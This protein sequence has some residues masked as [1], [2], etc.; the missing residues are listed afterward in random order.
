MQ[1]NTDIRSK[2]ENLIL[3]NPIEEVIDEHVV[4][5]NIDSN[6]S[7]IW[8]LLFM[9]GYLKSTSSSSFGDGTIACTMQI[10]NNE[11][12]GF[13]KRLVKECFA[14]NNSISWYNN[15]ITDLTS[16]N[17]DSFIK[18]LERI[19]LNIVSTKDTE[20]PEREKFYHGL[21]LGL[22]VGLEDSYEIRSNK[23]SGLGF[24]DLA[25]I[26]KDPK[27]HKI[28]IV[29]ELKKAN[30][31]KLLPAKADEAFAQINTKKYD[32][33]LRAR[34]IKKIVKIGIAFSAKTLQ[35]KHE[36]LEL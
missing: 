33:E 11:I 4:F 2:I 12:K 17:I 25:L 3:G 26:P 13:Y 28:G 6:I 19:M 16:G 24:Y 31:D 9:A 5:A 34:G 20:N 14:V 36:F 35:A 27:P 10:P 7:A 8:S 29:I 32:T 21:M 1:S 30:T 18:K 15:F 22:I 23:E